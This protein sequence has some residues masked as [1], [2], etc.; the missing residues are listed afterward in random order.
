MGETSEIPMILAAGSCDPFS[1]ASVASASMSRERTGRPAIAIDEVEKHIAGSRRQFLL[2]FP[3]GGIVRRRAHRARRSVPCPPTVM[4]CQRNTSISTSRRSAASRTRNSVAATRVLP[5]L[6]DPVK[7]NR[8]WALLQEQ[9]L[10][11]ASVPSATGFWI[12]SGS[13]PRKP[14]SRSTM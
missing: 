2:D 1:C 11:V 13:L 6:C 8:G 9:L 7:T 10:S 4:F 14:S 12:L 3:Q 5:A